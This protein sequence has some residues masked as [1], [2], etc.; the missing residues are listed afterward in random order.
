MQ[1]AGIDKEGLEDVDL[2]SPVP[3]KSSA[4]GSEQ[5]GIAFNTRIQLDV[6]VSLKVLLKKRI[7]VIPRIKR[8]ICRQFDL[9]LSGIPTGVKF[10]RDFDGSPYA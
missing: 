2:V 7:T 3:L 8:T 9:G 1:V 10:N 4:K 5:P 6:L